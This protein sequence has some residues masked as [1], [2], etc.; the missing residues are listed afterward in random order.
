MTTFYLV[1]QYVA[2]HES[3]T[4]WDFS[5]LYS[6]RE[7]ALAACRDYSYFIAPALLDQQLPHERRE[8]SGLEYPLANGN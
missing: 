2:T 1:G 8:W 4:V 3:G 6:T 7:L 5:G